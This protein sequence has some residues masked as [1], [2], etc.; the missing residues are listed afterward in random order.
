MSATVDLPRPDARPTMSAVSSSDAAMLS[1]SAAARLIGCS[2][3]TVLRRIEAGAL[4][5]TPGGKL[6]RPDVLR[7]LGDL[8]SS[9]QEGRPQVSTDT[10]SATS[11]N[12]PAGGAEVSAEAVAMSGQPSVPLSVVTL[13]QEQLSDVLEQLA[14]QREAMQRVEEAHA[15]EREAMISRLDRLLP[16]PDSIPAAPRGWW[17]RLFG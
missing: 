3:S 2:R 6:H 7:V 15:A 12:G 8:Y 17:A 11:A 5:R 1:V 16:V 9:D 4:T 14:E 13:M 10:R